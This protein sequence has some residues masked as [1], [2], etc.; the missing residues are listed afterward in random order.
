M[1]ILWLP[2][3]ILLIQSTLPAQES[4]TITGTVSVV[5]QD[6]RLTDAIVT[7]VR[8]RDNVHAAQV[9]SGADGHF[10]IDATSPEQYRLFVEVPGFRRFSLERVN[11][12]A[13]QHLS[14]PVLRLELGNCAMTTPGAAS[15]SHSALFPPEQGIG[16]GGTL[17][18]DP[19]GGVPRIRL[20]LHRDGYPEMKTD[21]DARG[22]WRF[23]G[24]DPGTWLLSTHR[25]GYRKIEA[26][27]RD[28]QA[29]LEIISELYLKRCP[30]WICA[31][32]EPRPIC[33]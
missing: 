26:T 15:M 11:I 21:S 1:R 25:Y 29:G 7:L 5:N 17:R 33:E 9:R 28:V 8:S 2:F 4:G 30:F 6:I 32:P 10:R 20:Q 3:L 24:M 19:R 22:N 16:I 14:L 23:T 27:Y 12:Q 31:W 18:R 13:G